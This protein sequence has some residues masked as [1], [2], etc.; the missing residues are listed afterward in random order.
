V[1]AVSELCAASSFDVGNFSGVGEKNF[2]GVGWGIGS[3]LLGKM[4][5]EKTAAISLKHPINRDDDALRV[6][7]VTRFFQPIAFVTVICLR[8]GQL[9]SAAM[10]NQARR[11]GLA[12]DLIVKH[13]QS[14]SELPE[15]QGSTMPRPS[16]RARRC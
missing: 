14:T 4:W 8:V 10:S 16:Y 11:C 5:S 3:A 7:A 1:V 13:T 6:G 15:T 2:M 12:D 9:A